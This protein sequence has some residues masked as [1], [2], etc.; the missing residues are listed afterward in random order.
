MDLLMR[1]EFKKRH[2]N[3]LQALKQVLK[4]GIK[5]ETV[6]KLF[7]TLR[8]EVREQHRGSIFS[9]CFS[10]QLKFSVALC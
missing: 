7:S 9:E 3:V 1:G 6:S 10:V 2:K 5:K 4:N 8:Y